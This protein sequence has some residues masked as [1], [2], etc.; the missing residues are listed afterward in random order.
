MGVAGSLHATAPWTILVSC[1]LLFALCLAG[2][3]AIRVLP[4]A[5]VGDSLSLYTTRSNT[6]VMFKALATGLAFAP[7]LIGTHNSKQAWRG[8]SLGM[9]L[10]ALIVAMTVIAERRVT[11]G[12]LDFSQELRVSG[13][14][15]SMHIGGQ[16]IDAYWGLALPFVFQFPTEKRLS[17]LALWLLQLLSLY[18][19]YATMSRALIAFAVVSIIGLAILKFILRAE[20]NNGRRNAEG[21]SEN[22]DGS[23]ARRK[24][25]A[26]LVLGL[27]S[28]LIIAGGLL[29][30]GNAVQT[31]FKSTAADWKTRTDHWQHVLS[32]VAAGDWRQ[33]YLGHG[34]G[35]YP[36][37]IR[38]VDGHPTQPIAMT[39]D[40][41]VRLYAGQQIY[42]EQWIT[43]H[44]A[45]PITVTANC[46]KMG[47]CH[48][49]AQVCRKILLQSFECTQVELLPLA[50]QSSELHAELLADAASAT[51]EPMSH[52]RQNCPSTFGF[53]VSGGQGEFVT[54]SNVR[55]TDARGVALI[56]NGNFE[57]GSRRWFFTSDDHL[58]WRAKN[59]W[60]HQAVEMGWLGVA[61]LAI[62]VFG[63]VFPALRG[64]WRDGQWPAVVLLWSLLG[65][66]VMGLFGTLIDV[67]WLLTFFLIVLAYL[68]G[69]A[70]R[71]SVASK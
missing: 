21:S 66:L 30:S 60:V 47:N 8:F 61:A 55:V 39:D 10:S 2:I 58:I 56:A 69:N 37:F 14:F 36:W 4:V 28:L 50:S 38:E 57:H 1:G 63:T 70:N 3:Q 19:I 48:L 65:F 45:F 42:L 52:W 9:Q 23:K 46:A 26:H 51:Q 20:Q 62:L 32:V 12:L 7:L 29:M 25:V 68:Q 34:L 18:A 41:A 11:Y 35:T 54:I 13:P 44:I 53:S 31:R 24:A 71:S 67:P 16:H 6:L 49:H 43:S 59:M 64:I 40:H 27:C 15:A 33:Q 5:V 22:R 17:T